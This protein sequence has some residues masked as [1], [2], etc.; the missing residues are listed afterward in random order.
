MYLLSRLVRQNNIKVV[1]TGEGSDEFLGGYNIF[2]EDKIRRFWARQ[3][4]SNWRPLLLRRLY[5]YVSDLSR[6]GDAYLTAFFRRGLTDVDQRGYSHRI[7]WSNTARLQR[8]FSDGLRETLAGYDPAE[9]FLGRLNGSFSKWSALSQ[10]QYIEV[11]PL[12]H[13]IFCPHRATG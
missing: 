2:Q 1:L 13:P 4:D 11:S 10:A 8:L 12:C 5:P 3:P 6:G 9:E 7:R